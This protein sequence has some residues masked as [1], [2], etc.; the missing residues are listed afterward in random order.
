MPAFLDKEEVVQIFGENPEEGEEDEETQDEN[1][2]SGENTYIETNKTFYKQ[3]NTIVLN[4]FHLISAQEGD[5]CVGTFLLF[6]CLE[7]RN[8]IG[9]YLGKV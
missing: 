5:I 7:R 6:P 1:N 4:K 8:T 2:T 9:R 3:N